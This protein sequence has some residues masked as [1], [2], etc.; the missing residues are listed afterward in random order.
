MNSSRIVV[1]IVAVM[2][3]CTL[4]LA[5]KVPTVR[6]C[7]GIQLIAADGTVVYARTLEFAVDLQSDVIV[8]PRGYERIGETPDGKQGLKWEVKYANVGANGVGVPY[9]F[10]GVNE[11]G[12]AAGT[13]YF[14]GFAGY[15]NYE[16]NDAGK[17]LAPYQ[18]NSWILDNFATVEEVEA[19]I[20]KIL[21]ASV[22]F[23]PWGYVLPLHYVVH[24]AKGDCIVIEIVDGQLKVY[25]NPLG[26]IT[27]PPTFDWHMANLRNYVNLSFTNAP[28]MQLGQ[29]TLTALGQG[30]GMLGLPGDFTPPSRFVRAA[31][32]SQSAYQAET[33]RAAV[34]EAFHILNNFDIPRGSAR[35]R[36]KD[37]HGNPPADYTQ[38]TSANDLKAKQYYFR[39]FE[40][41]R[42]R[43][44]SLMKMD[45]DAKDIATI[46]MK[47]DEEIET[48]GKKD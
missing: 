29:A 39:T 30:S 46:S 24:D 19:D 1:K 36:G 8:V 47:G 38:W 21:V 27:N 15:M 10:D 12:L 37:I 26:V 31:E 40:N 18:V 44:I 14:P 42:I 35:E 23:K 45:L 6:A 22:V 33:G 4:L 9:L 3:A 16:P 5:G 41:S 28:A 13:F 43:M 20:D 7:T 32:F 34:L 2:A 48:L 25:K 17:T 11:K